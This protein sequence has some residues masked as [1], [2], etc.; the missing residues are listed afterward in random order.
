MKLGFHFAIQL[1]FVAAAVSAA[2]GQ[3]KLDFDLVR[4]VNLNQNA[5]GYYRIEH[6]IGRLPMSAKGKLRLHATNTLDHKVQ[7]GSFYSGCSCITASISQTEVNPGEKFVLDLLFDTKQRTALSDQIAAFSLARNKDGTEA[8]DIKLKYK[9]DGLVAF[10]D[11]MSA[12][13]VPEG[14]TTVNCALP[15]IAERPARIEDLKFTATGDL[16]SMKFE[17]QEDKSNHQYFLACSINVEGM[18]SVGM[19]GE[20]MLE[21]TRT[22]RKVSTLLML[23]KLSRVTMAPTPLRFRPSGGVY[24]ASAIV[25]ITD[26]NDESAQTTSSEK[27]SAKASISQAEAKVIVTNI[28]RGVARLAFEVKPD[29]PDDDFTSEKIEEMF[30]VFTKGGEKFSEKCSVVF[31]TH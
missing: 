12:V 18:G 14:K 6:D 16:Q 8:I 17:I 28:S 7:L 31:S 26:D 1:T 5:G 27:I 2:L 23:K 20:V 24:K 29:N 13:E 3:E 25:R 21:D 15:F 11:A 4:E 30:V 9:I 22:G 10:K 19:S